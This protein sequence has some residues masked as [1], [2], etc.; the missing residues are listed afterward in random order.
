MIRERG[1]LLVSLVSCA[2][3][4]EEGGGI[5][6]AVGELE[7]VTGTTS[8][9]GAG[10]M[11]LRKS[12]LVCNEAIDTPLTELMLSLLFGWFLLCMRGRLLRE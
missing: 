6:V 2:G 9:V 3:D 11:L 4:F 12:A 10:V 5:L 7:W 1:E 8:G